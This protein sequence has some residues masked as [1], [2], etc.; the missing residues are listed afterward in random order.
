MHLGNSDRA[1]ESAYHYF[2]DRMLQGENPVMNFKVR[3]C[4][5]HSDLIKI[6][7]WLEKSYQTHN[8]VK[9]INLTPTLAGGL[10]SDRWP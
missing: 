2:F 5:T 7:A 10:C 6:Q 1:R 4:L 9:K 8:N 3:L